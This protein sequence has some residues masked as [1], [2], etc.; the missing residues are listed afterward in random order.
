MTMDS[1]S[2]CPKCGAPV[3][4]GSGRCPFCGADLAIRQR[5]A[6]GAGAMPGVGLAPQAPG[7]ANDPR[8]TS[9]AIVG[10][11]PGA[12]RYTGAPLAPPS[13]STAVTN[14]IVAILVPL[15]GGGLS[16][17][18]WTMLSKPKPAPAPVAHVAAPINPL[19][20]PPPPVTTS[21]VIDVKDPAHVDPIDFLA[22]AKARAL[23]WDS[24][25]RL[26]SIAAS[27]VVD[28]KIDLSK[29]DAR[30][31][32]TY[33]APDGAGRHLVAVTR[34]GAVES[35][36]KGA[37]GDD[38]ATVDEPLCVTFPA[39]RAA[40]AAGLPANAKLEMRYEHDR[41]LG[42]AIWSIGV[43][44]SKDAPRTIDGNSCAIVTR[45]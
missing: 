43:V 35:S 31:V 27:P 39:V 29:P 19:S 32:Y 45:R 4:T 24:S 1:S 42:R 34:S 16:Y 13:R 37:A 26:F 30:L 41:P 3:G 5:A 25:A 22:R 9:A 18:F 44:G 23:K 38:S 40:L 7:A 20:N 28:K 2:S 15:V 33:V 12:S 6:D 17:V 11:A 8:A 21:D 36:E 14:A 10:H